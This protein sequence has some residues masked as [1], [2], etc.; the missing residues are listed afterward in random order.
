MG[1]REEAIQQLREAI[2]RQAEKPAAQQFE[3]MVARGAIDREGNVLI[4]GPERPEPK[5]KRT[6]KV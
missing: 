1:R 3:E 6:K 4:R 5:R 2:L